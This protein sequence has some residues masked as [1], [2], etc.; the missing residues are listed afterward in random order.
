VRE[1]PRH[2][3]QERMLLHEGGVS[4]GERGKINIVPTAARMEC[5]VPGIDGQS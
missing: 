4:T 2:T 3:A 5:G 1:T